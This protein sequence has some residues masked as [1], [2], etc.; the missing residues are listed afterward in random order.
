L[1]PYGFDSL[2]FDY[3]AIATAKDGHYKVSLHPVAA[4]KLLPATKTFEV[5]HGETH[6]VYVPVVV[7]HYTSTLF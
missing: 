2:W 4:G 5:L 6:T 3:V 1:T 7:R